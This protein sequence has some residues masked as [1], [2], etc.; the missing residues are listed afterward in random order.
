[1]KTLLTAILIGVITAIIPPLG[2]TLF[3]IWIAQWVVN[4]IIGEIR[5]ERQHQAEVSKTAQEIQQGIDEAHAE[6]RNIE[7][8]RKNREYTY[9]MSNIAQEKRLDREIER[10][11]SMIY[12][13]EKK[14]TTTGLI[15]TLTKYSMMNINDIEDKEDIIVR[16]NK[17]AKELINKDSEDGGT[18][19]KR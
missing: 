3:I 12:V 8:T 10:A 16:V 7:Y 14:P 6:L 13:Y 11:Q 5:Q 15:P 9:I 4:T 17:I 2:I 18:D 1:M 19:G